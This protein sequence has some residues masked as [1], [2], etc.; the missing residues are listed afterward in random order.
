MSDVEL[1]ENLKPYV[2][3]LG[4]ELAVEFFL[5]FG[6]AGLYLPTRCP[7]KTGALVDL[8]GAEKAIALGLK[9]GFGEVEV[10]TAKPFIIQYLFSVDWKINDICRTVHMSRPGVRFH[11]SPEVRARRKQA[12]D[13]ARC[14][15]AFQQRQLTLF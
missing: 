9:M 8:V 3:V 5:T 11:L 10:P 12:E 4:A 2:E 15:L 6:G 14:K 1:P 13:R 7:R